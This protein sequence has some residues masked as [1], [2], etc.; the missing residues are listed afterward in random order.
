LF[1]ARLNNVSFF[2]FTFPF[3]LLL[4]SILYTRTHNRWPRQRV[5][6]C[7]PGVFFPPVFTL[8][9]PLGAQGS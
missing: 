4:A 5:Q 2:S 7:Q 9:A 3:L 8:K 6:G 1:L